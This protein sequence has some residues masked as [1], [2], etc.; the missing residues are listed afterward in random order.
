MRQNLLEEFMEPQDERRNVQVVNLYFFTRD[1]ARKR[2]KVGPHIKRYGLVFDK[3]VVDTETFQSYP[4]GYMPF[5]D[6][7]DMVNVETLITL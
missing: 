7:A 4:Y 2:L 6:N 1:P 5:L 3:R